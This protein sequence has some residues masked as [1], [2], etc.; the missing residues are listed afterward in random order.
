M[1]SLIDLLMKART[2]RSRASFYT[3][4]TLVVFAGLSLAT[5]VSSREVTLSADRG[6]REVQDTGSMSWHTPA[7]YR[8]GG[9]AY[10][11]DGA[12]VMAFQLP[13]LDAGES[14]TGGS[15]AATLSGIANTPS[16]T[17]DIYG[18]LSRSS[19]AILATDYVEGAFADKSGAWALVQNFALP[20][21]AS[22]RLTSSSSASDA[23]ADYINA[24]YAAGAEAGDWLILVLAPSNSD[25]SNYR[26]WTFVSADG[27]SAPTLT[28]E[29]GEGETA[30]PNTVPV[31]SSL[32][33][34]SVEAGSSFSYTFPAFTDA[35]D[36]ALSYTF[37]GAPT[38]VSLSGRTFSGT[39]PS[40]ASASSWTIVLT[41][42]DHAGASASASFSLSVT[43]APAEPVEETT[44]P[45]VT[46]T[47]SSSGGGSSTADRT[48]SLKANGADREV[49]QG[50]SMSWYTQKFYRVGGVSYGKDG[51][52][53]IPFQLPELS[54]GESV[55]SATFSA[56]LNGIGNVPSGTVD[57]YGLS[58]RT[59]SS[60]LS[61]DYLEGT[62]QDR[63]GAWAL[64]AS[65]AI[66]TSS[67]GSISTS[68]SS[69]TAIAD[70]ISAQYESG[71]EAGD[72]IFIVLAPSKADESNYRYWEFASSE[73]GA[74][75]VLSL[76]I[77]SGIS[78]GGS[79]TTNSAPVASTLSD[80]TL[81]EGEALSYTFPAFTDPDGDTVSYAVSGS[82]SWISRSGR[83]FSG[84]AP[85]G[86]GGNSWTV[87]VTGSDP[88]GASASASFTIT[89]ETPI[90]TE[91]EETEDPVIPVSSEDTST[92]DS[93]SGSSSGATTESREILLTGNTSDRE[94]QQGGTTSWPTQ[95]TFRVGGVAYNKDGAAVMA[96][97]LPT[98]E[99]GESVIGG[100]FSA[101][102]TGIANTPAGTVDLHGLS[103]RSSSTVLGG[104]FLEGAFADGSGSWALS[105]SFATPS[106]SVGV[107]TTGEDDSSR[108]A[109]Y[110][111][112]QYDSGAVAGD[113]IFLVLAPSHSDESNYRYWTFASADGSPKPQLLLSI[114]TAA[115]AGSTN[116]A[117]VA[118]SLT[119]QSVEAGSA[120]SYTIPA[121]SDADG[122]TVTYSAT[123]GPS[124][125]TLSGRT[126][127]GSAPSS[128]AGGEWTVTVKGTDTSGA[129][130][131]ASF[132]LEVTEVATSSSDTESEDSSSSGGGYTPIPDAPVE[133]S[134]VIQLQG[135]IVD[136]AL[137]S[138][139]G[140]MWVGSTSI[141]IGGSNSGIDSAAVYAFQLPTLRDG[142]IITDVKLSFYMNGYGLTP[143]G[144]VDLYA[145]DYGNDPFTDGGFYYSGVYGGDT[146]SAVWPIQDNVFSNNQGTGLVSTNSVGSTNMIAFLANQYLNGALEGDMIYFR[147]NSDRANESD[148]RYW[149]IASANDTS[150]RPVLSIEVSYDR[151][152]S[153]GS[154][155][156]AKPVE[157]EVYYEGEYVPFS[158]DEDLF[159]SVLD[160]EDVTWISNIDGFLDRGFSIATDAL[161]VGVHNVSAIWISNEGSIFRYDVT[162]EID[163]VSMLPTSASSLSSRGVTWYFDKAYPTGRFINGDHYV[164]A[165]QGLTLTKITPGW[166]GVKN[167]AEINP[168]G[169]G[170][171][172]NHGFDT[173]VE[174]TT[175]DASLN[176]ADD[177]PIHVATNSSVVSALGSAAETSLGLFLDDVAVLTILPTRPADMSFRPPY[178]GDD[179]RIIGTKDDLDMSF[180]Q[181]LPHPTNMR[182]PS[183][184]V[185][186]VLL[187]VIS[188]WTNNYLKTQAGQHKYGRQ[189]AY[190]FAD[191]V[192]WL[193]LDYYDAQKLPVLENVV[194]RGIDAY[195]SAKS[196]VQFIADGGIN[197]GRKLVV[198]VAAKALND[199]EM[200]E[201]ADGEKHHHF[202]E[203]TQHLYITQ[204]IINSNSKFNQSHLGMAE[205]AFN[206]WEKPDLTTPEWS[207]PYRNVNGSPNIG[208][209][210]AVEFMG[211]RELW[212][213]EPF[214]EY[215]ENR[216]WPRE[217]ANRA[218]GLN[219]IYKFYGELWDTYIAE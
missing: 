66:P 32:T 54:D 125:L 156:I 100:E 10:R 164:V 96:F 89:V 203:D 169:A 73:S 67:T 7:T 195:G 113:W 94:V 80:Y 51:A 204:D 17:V 137:L 63:T 157:R 44:T 99:E 70:Y 35:D 72:W 106:T 194:Q 199:P 154:T 22:G 30:E 201:W 62:F 13:S 110:I 90:I 217:E 58:S 188:N 25:E 142:E 26:Y 160:P 185:G 3:A 98:L 193:N 163:P 133:G 76:G 187:D 5:T 129:S 183:Y 122:D 117:P 214:F 21:T 200:L 126:F 168:K 148:Y 85:S 159:D 23:I 150:K 81:S 83:T 172:N 84:T 108:I 197:V 28:L 29:I 218:N 48:V 39:A 216:Y 4:L 191:A 178:A 173:R 114:G 95:K 57:V 42:T 88:S 107:L 2:T 219:Y 198:V 209:Y 97:Q 116:S 102:L 16:G 56:Q 205:W 207:A 212:N 130:D 37:S 46:D 151:V 50:G 189:I 139:G 145:V 45:P 149:E 71:A 128:A 1:F 64:S 153:A 14:V 69:S 52:A 215:L 132:A 61:T 87:T 93:G 104:D 208:T 175:Y 196:G 60:V 43:E 123:G 140:S 206:H 147:M 59:S 53:V 211:L 12:A 162:V 135:E 86:S 101:K 180:L 75:P 131:S 179:K 155:P 210:L 213:H 124:W 152:N 136:N 121:F 55:V 127:S 9:V 167:G 6:D 79:A 186:N 91:P 105:Q 40:S 15:F 115:T 27:S 171:S 18:L 182:Y 190:G 31:A 112:E 143:A 47:G 176:I 177:L 141:R 33:S 138:N 165:P 170:R 20:N 49:Q 8:V 19:A 74:G 119:A 146:N 192:L 111:T 38:W 11:K 82:P 65:F 118:S 202:Q 36:E 103:S 134:A 77:G 181:N 144:S 41:G 24:Q 34:Q 92:E 68:S 78:S 184:K 109:T 174:T 120:V 161:S 166:D 158:L